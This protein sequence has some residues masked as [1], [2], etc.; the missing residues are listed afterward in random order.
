MVSTGCSVY[1][2]LLLSS[3]VKAKKLWRQEGMSLVSTKDEH[4]FLPL[5]QQ[6][7]EVMWTLAASMP[8][9]NCFEPTSL[10]FGMTCGTLA[11][12]CQIE[13]H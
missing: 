9:E 6:V 1:R 2:A 13:G 10:Q 4:S 11:C 3:C 5:A 12:A 8:E 7:S